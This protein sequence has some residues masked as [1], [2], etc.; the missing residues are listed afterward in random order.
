VA[1]LH[2]RAGP[3]PPTALSWHGPAVSFLAD[4]HQSAPPVGGHSFVRRPWDT[5]R[6]FAVPLPVASPTS[7]GD[8]NVITLYKRVM[9]RSQEPRCTGLTLL[10]V[11]GI[12]LADGLLVGRQSAN[13]APGY[14]GDDAEPGLA[15]LTTETGGS[16]A[17]DH[18]DA[19]PGTG[20]ARPPPAM[21]AQIPKWNRASSPNPL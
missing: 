13:A 21:S 2:G 9:W 19:R 1:R 7:T 17:S 14:R 20:R 15:A 8:S 3:G 18:A 11:G 10:L 4:F 16:L 12:T 6:P 5:M